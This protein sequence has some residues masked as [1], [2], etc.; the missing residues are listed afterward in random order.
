VEPW[1][2]TFVA[3]PGECH[4]HT[5]PNTLAEATKSAR[6]TGRVPPT[7]LALPGWKR[8]RARAQLRVRFAEVVVLL[9][10][11]GVVKLAGGGN[12]PRT[13]SS[14]D[15]VVGLFGRGPLV[16]LAV[17]EGAHQPSVLL[18]GRAAL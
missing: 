18:G 3:G 12:S 2:Q 11:A 1:S 13:K 10:S 4:G 14:N 16:A 7:A 9:V 5:N 8:A 17:V 6:A 15:L